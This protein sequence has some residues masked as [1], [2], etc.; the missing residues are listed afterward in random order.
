MSPTWQ[1]RRAGNSTAAVTIT[2]NT[3]SLPVQ[4]TE[5]WPETFARR[6]LADALCEA[7]AKYWEHRAETFEWCAPRAD[8]YHGQ[9]TRDELNAAWLRCMADARRCR[10]HAALLRDR[11]V[12]AARDEWQNLLNREV[13]A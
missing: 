6:V 7:S 13:A 1:G 8:D 3:S 9:A 12:S 4:D 11:S 2:T 10:A 5:S